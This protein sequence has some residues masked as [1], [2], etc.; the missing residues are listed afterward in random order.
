VPSVPWN[1]QHLQWSYQV[2]SES[3]EWS[4]ITAKAPSWILWLEGALDSSPL[5]EPV[6]RNR[7]A[8]IFRL[9]GPVP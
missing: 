7:D 8:V 9:K 6:Y 1:T 3:R 2:L 5:F 4:S